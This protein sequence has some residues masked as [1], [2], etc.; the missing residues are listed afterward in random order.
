[1]YS[2][3][4]AYLVKKES[5]YIS[6][7]FDSDKDKF[8]EIYIKKSEDKQ[9]KSK[10]IKKVTSKNAKKYSVLKSELLNY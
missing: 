1:M 9:G 6:K 8:K 10:E 4:C 2:E 5:A 3:L 7:L